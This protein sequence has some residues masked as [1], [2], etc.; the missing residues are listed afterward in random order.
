[1][2]IS[3]RS[4]VGN[5]T[6]S[7]HLTSCLEAAQHSPEQMDFLKGA[8]GREFIEHKSYGCL[9]AWKEGT[10]FYAYTHHSEQ[11]GQSFQTG[12]IWFSVV[13]SLHLGSVILVWK[14]ASIS[15]MAE[16]IWAFCLGFLITGPGFSAWEKV[17]NA[18]NSFSDNVQLIL[19]TKKS[20]FLSAAC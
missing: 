12:E 4:S 7:M 16:L 8:K 17:W 5:H 1:M 2:E 20:F 9:T 13:W 3:T 15:Q 18:E 11:K 10:S 6:V 19:K 14:R